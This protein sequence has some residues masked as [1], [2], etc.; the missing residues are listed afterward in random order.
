VIAESTA[1][2]LFA[3]RDPLGATFT[4]GRGRT[5]TVV[6]IVGDIVKT[7]DRTEVPPAYV[8]SGE[9]TRQ[10]TIVVRARTRQETTL[11]AIKR[12]LS[13]LAPGVP[14]TARWWSD[15]I[16]SVTAY[17]NPRF[18]TLVLGSF[19]TL[20]IGLTALGIFAI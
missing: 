2:V 14:V 7:L 3:D 6:G 8:V 19:A 11:V 1:R 17:R 10:L 9:A 12:E 13:A 4:N 5:F 18:Q 20:A 15:D 16:A